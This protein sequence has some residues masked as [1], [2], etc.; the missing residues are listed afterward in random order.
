[1]TVTPSA[2]AARST[3]SSTRGPSTLG[4]SIRN[5]APSG[6]AGSRSWPVTPS[7]S[8]TSPTHLIRPHP[9]FILAERSVVFGYTEK[10]FLHPNYR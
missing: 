5:A 8:N 7:P 6:K 1:L 9:S 10:Y 4:I 3:A 2:W